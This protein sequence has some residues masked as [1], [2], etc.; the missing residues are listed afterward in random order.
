MNTPSA[1][2]S[3]FFILLH[4]LSAVIVLFALGAG[5]YLST[6]PPEHAARPYLLQLH[7]LFGLLILALTLLLFLRHQQKP[8]FPQDFPRWKI[9]ASSAGNFLI[10]ICLLLLPVSGYL[11]ASYS[12]IPMNF[13]DF[14]LPPWGGEDAALAVL[15]WRIHRLSATVLGAL[16]LVH[17]LF[18]LVSLSKKD[19]MGYRMLPAEPQNR[20]QLVALKR[21][22]EAVKLANK[23]AINIRLMGWLAFWLQLALFFVSV[24]LLVFATS[25]RAF[26]PGAAG[27][28]DG[29][30][31]ANYGVLILLASLV[32]A[33]Y[34]TKASRRIV[35]NPEAYIDP[36]KRF[37]FWFFGPGVI[38]NVTGI[39]VSFLGV[40]ASI[41]LLI[42]KTVS[43]PPGI[44]ITDPNKIIRALDVFILMI[45]FN[46]LIAHFIGAIVTFWLVLR[47]AKMRQDCLKA[48]AAPT[49]KAIE[50]PS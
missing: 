49:V 24:L 13:R 6:M 2:Y 18:F 39:L 28:L 1:S 21:P 27:T 4:W 33:F 29:M 3:L 16:I 45:N 37:A 44:A 10:Y 31:W 9:L 35:S 17:S 50:S 8:P 12:A 43:Q 47:A 48:M 41:S 14:S 30:F 15:F 23:L 46:L 11:Y 40:A 42:A 26:S 36:H 19:G 34:Y 20:G 5:W 25:G 7:I 32:M 38:V 22:P